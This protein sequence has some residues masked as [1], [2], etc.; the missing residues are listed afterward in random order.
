MGA[1]V[2]SMGPLLARWEWEPSLARWE[3]PLARWELSWARREPSWAL[4]GSRRWLDGSQRGLNGSHYGLDGSCLWLDGS[5]R[6]LDGSL[7]GLDE[8]GGWLD[9][10]QREPWSA[11]SCVGRQRRIKVELRASHGA[12]RTASVRRRVVACCKSND[13]TT[14]ARRYRFGK[15]SYKMKLTS[16]LE[17]IKIQ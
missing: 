6:G 1:F 17:L 15:Q 13:G 9:G 8:S 14:K 3:P 12:P 11:R 7:C 16:Y 4:D 5:Q 10:S 2:R